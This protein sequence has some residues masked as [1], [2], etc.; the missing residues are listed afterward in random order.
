[1]GEH[2]HLG[3][4]WLP[5]DPDSRVF[6]VLHAPPNDRMVLNTAGVLAPSGATDMTILGRT[7]LGTR[8]TLAGCLAVSERRVIASDPSDGSGEYYVAQA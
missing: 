1:M 8:V 4:W 6:G 5:E 3:G 7:Q 2:T